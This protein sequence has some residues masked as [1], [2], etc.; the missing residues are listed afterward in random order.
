MLTHLL[1]DPPAGLSARAFLAALGET[2]PAGDRDAVA[3]LYRPETDPSTVELLVG[4]PGVV[5]TVEDA[6]TRDDETRL[7]LLPYRQI[8]ERG[9]ACH[10]DGAPAI[11]VRLTYRRRVPLPEM[12]AALPNQPLTVTDGEFDVADSAY[13]DSVRSTIATEIGSGEGSNFVIRRSYRAQVKDHSAE[14][15]LSL[16]RRLLRQENGVY[17]T[18]LVCVG[19]RTLV[20][21]TPE[22]HVRVDGDQVTMNPISGTYRYPGQRPDP[23]GL[24]RFLADRKETDEL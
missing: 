1:A 8:A 17:W 16:F 14:S 9:Y 11:A 18:F 15:A 21:A 19:G 5:D 6:L 12:L 22:S 2:V 7:V 24:R 10:D 13:A 4:V 3:L 20:G 23:A